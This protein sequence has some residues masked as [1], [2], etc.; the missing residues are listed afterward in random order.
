MSVLILALTVPG[1]HGGSPGGAPNKGAVTGAGQT[2]VAG[3]TSGS[4]TAVCPGQP[5]GAKVLTLSTNDNVA[6]SAVEMGSGSK[7]VLLVP[8]VG[9]RGKCGWMPYATELAGKGLRVLVFDMPCQGGSACPK[10]STGSGSSSGSSSGS[11][12]GSGSGSADSTG[13]FGDEGIQA[14]DTALNELHTDGAKTVVV[15][16]ASGGAT[17][18]LAAE[19]GPAASTA[20]GVTAVV[21]LSADELGDL[22]AAAPTIHV[23]VLMAVADGDPNVSANDERKVFDALAAPPALRT[24]DVQPNG[25]GHGWELLDGQGFKDKVTAFVTGYLTADY[26]VWG[27]GSRTIVLSNESDQDQWAWQTY[28]GHF[29]AE[30]YKVAMWDYADQDPVANLAAI[31]ADLRAHGSGPL[32]LLGASKGGKVSLVAAAGIKPPVTAVVTLSAEATMNPNSIDVA[33]YVK[34]LTCPVLLLTAPQDGYGSADAA[35]TFQAD[36]PNLVRVVTYDNA[37][38]DHGTQLLT[39]PEGPKVTADID[40]YLKAR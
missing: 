12:S 34:R 20:P 39:G 26:T 33:S 18:A 9:E 36:L 30:G 15:V 10:P 25:A 23:P 31:V 22:P 21:A 38:A 32:F 14:V 1:C 7:G 19:A 35:K 13:G 5:A 27:T 28:A 40:A 8:E 11:G 17:T 16:G 3:A 37:G 2:V 24:L 6:L 4:A 29:V